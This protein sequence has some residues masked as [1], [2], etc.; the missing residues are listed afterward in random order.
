MSLR[1][2]VGGGIGDIYGTVWDTDD[3]GNKLVRANGTPIASSPDKFLGNAQ[4]DW[5]VGGLIP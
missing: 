2:Q 3:N 1:A 5:L 4:P